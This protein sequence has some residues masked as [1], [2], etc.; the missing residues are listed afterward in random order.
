MRGPRI[1][2]N[3]AQ[4]GADL[5]ADLALH[6]LTGDQRDRLPDEILKPT[7]HRLGDDIGNR[8]ALTFGH[9]GVSI[10]LTAR[11]ADEF[12]AAVADPLSGRPTRDARYTT[13]TD[14]TVPVPPRPH[15]RAR[16]LSGPRSRPTTLTVQPAARC[17]ALCPGPWPP[18]S[19]R[20]LN[21]A[22]LMAPTCRR[23][24]DGTP[25]PDVLNHD[26]KP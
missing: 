3:L 24:A 15:A 14:V 20:P 1:R 13:S 21:A 8:H 23:A 25:I 26:R 4:L 22:P 6:Q 19:R 5:A 12:G 11:T 10:R 9:R 18:R 7:I 2:R 16:V 17:A